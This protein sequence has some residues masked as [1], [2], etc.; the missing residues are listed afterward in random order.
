MCKFNYC[1]SFLSAKVFKASGRPS[2]KSQR[3]VDNILKYFPDFDAFSLSPPSS[4]AEV[5]RHL[6]EEGRQKEISSSFLKGV[7]DFKQLLRSKLSPKQSFSGP[8]LVTGQG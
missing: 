2:E 8:G 5:M 4:D 6:S 1:V 7:E 3:V